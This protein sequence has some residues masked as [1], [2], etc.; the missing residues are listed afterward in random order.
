M[1]D[2]RKREEGLLISLTMHGTN[3]PRAVYYLCNNFIQIA[4]E[5]LPMT[6]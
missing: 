5:P 3:Q 6:L 2:V 4:H 1:K